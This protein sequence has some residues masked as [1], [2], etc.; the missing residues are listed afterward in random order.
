[1]STGLKLKVFR[2]CERGG[3]RRLVGGGGREGVGGW[4]FLPW[5][6]CGSVQVVALVSLRKFIYLFIL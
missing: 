6:K 3:G 2:V 5:E 4:G 1:M